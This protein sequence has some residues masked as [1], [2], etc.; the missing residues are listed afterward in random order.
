[1]AF[2]MVYLVL[3]WHTWYL[4]FS[5][6]KSV[7]GIIFIQIIWNIPRKD[8]GDKDTERD[9]GIDKDMARYGNLWHL[10]ATPK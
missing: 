8:F 1:M 4:I 5:I 9:F 2:G 7:Q 10:M 3:G 6:N